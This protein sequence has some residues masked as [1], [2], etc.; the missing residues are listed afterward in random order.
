MKSL[1]NSL[2]SL[3]AVLLIGQTCAKDSEEN[4]EE[5]QTYV[6][7]MYGQKKEVVEADWKKFI[8]LAQSLL[9]ISDSN[10]KSLRAKQAQATDGDLKIKWKLVITK[11]DYE[12]NQL[13]LQLQQRNLR[14][15]EE[16][17]DYDGTS[18]KTNT[19]F[20]TDWL[21]RIIELNTTLEEAVD[22]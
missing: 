2:F 15:L 8:S 11:S 4:M 7:S 20:K 22:E 13:K 18:G 3:A 19:D 21:H 10:M 16:L 1:R 17:K 12:L 5:D 6:E 9:S 14:F